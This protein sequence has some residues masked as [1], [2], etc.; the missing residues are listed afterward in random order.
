MEQFTA[1]SMA[2]TL[3]WDTF[4]WHPTRRNVTAEHG[5]VG[6]RSLPALRLAWRED[7]LDSR[8]AERFSPPRQKI[9][10]PPRSSTLHWTPPLKP[11]GRLFILFNPSGS[12]SAAGSGK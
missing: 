7:R 5:V 9:L 3:N 4:P 10:K 8:I 1:A 12:S 11:L 6:N 2:S